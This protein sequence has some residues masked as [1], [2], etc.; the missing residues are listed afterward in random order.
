MRTMNSTCST[1]YMPYWYGRTT[2]TSTGTVLLFCTVGTLRYG[3]VCITTVRVVHLHAVCSGIAD[4]VPVY[5][6]ACRIDW[7]CMNVQVDSTSIH[8]V[9]YWI[10]VLFCKR[11]R[12][13]CRYEMHCSNCIGFVRSSPIS[14]AFAALRARMPELWR[15]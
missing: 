10:S 13:G 14:Q 3:T 15:L 12:T 7:H 2:T 11:L 9:Q 4:T 6:T 5:R 1:G 8:S